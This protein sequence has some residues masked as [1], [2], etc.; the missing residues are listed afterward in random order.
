MAEVYRLR[1]DH[2][3][4]AGEERLRLDEPMVVQM[5]IDRSVVSIPVCLNRMMDEM[6]A[7]VLKRAG[8]Q[9]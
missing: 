9:E 7:E 1:L 4:V 6:K 3:M 8:E 2:Y 5:I